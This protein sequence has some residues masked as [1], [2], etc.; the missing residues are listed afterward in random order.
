[1]SVYFSK[2]SSSTHERLA[3][4]AAAPLTLTECGIDPAFL[5]DRLWDCAHLKRAPHSLWRS[6]EGHPDAA[7][8]AAEPANNNLQIQSVIPL[9]LIPRGL[10]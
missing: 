2:H 9:P 3:A 6:P 5:D 10:R 7:V 4:A 1:M 8:F